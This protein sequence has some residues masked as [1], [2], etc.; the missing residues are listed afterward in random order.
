L[1]SRATIALWHTEEIFHI[2]DFEIGDAPRANLSRRAQFFKRGYNVGEVGDPRWP[3]QQIEIE[4]VSTEAFEAC[5]ASTRNTVSRHMIGRDLGDQENAITLTGDRSADKFLGAIHF[6][7]VDRRHS[8][9]EAS[10]YRLFFIDLRTFSLSE[11]RRALAQGR[12]DSA[13]TKLDRAPCG[14]GGC[15]RGQI[16]SRCSCKRAKRHAES[17][18]FTPVQESHNLYSSLYDLFHHTNREGYGCVVKGHPACPRRCLPLALRNA[19]PV[20]CAVL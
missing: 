16:K 1:I 5:L 12:D 15:A 11:T 2:A 4:M 17:T 7:R 20:N 10:A 14:G 18:E 3:M 8:E 13:V 6:C 19:P 9:R